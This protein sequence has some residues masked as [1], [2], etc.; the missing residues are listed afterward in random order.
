MSYLLTFIS[1]AVFSIAVIVGII[2]MPADGLEYLF[3]S[4]SALLWALVICRPS[5]Q[6]DRA[7]D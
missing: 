3:A 2:G 6:K 4:L 7:N 1:G 5:E